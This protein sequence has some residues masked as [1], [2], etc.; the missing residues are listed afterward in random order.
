MVKSQ[1]QRWNLEDNREHS[2]CYMKSLAGE[3][4]ARPRLHSPTP[5]CGGG[6]EKRPR[7]AAAVKI[8]QALT[9]S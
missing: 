8:P 9:G 7:R 4:S 2:L 3:Q 1:G 6:E 5:A